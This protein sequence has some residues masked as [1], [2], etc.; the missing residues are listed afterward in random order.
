MKTQSFGRSAPPPRLKPNYLRSFVP[1]LSFAFRSP[2]GS[3]SL[4]DYRENRE[5]GE[6]RDNPLGVFPTA[7]FDALKIKS[8]TYKPDGPNKEDYWPDAQG[9]YWWRLILEDGRISEDFY[10]KKDEVRGFPDKADSD[11][12]WFTVYHAPSGTKIEGFSTQP[13]RAKGYP[14]NNGY[15]WSYAQ[16]DECGPIKAWMEEKDRNYGARVQ[17]E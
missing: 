9:R 11:R 1:F 14:D 15:Y 12:Y 2:A 4:K 17:R 13:D 16:Y 10:W 7:G 5:N 8:S 3:S 6:E